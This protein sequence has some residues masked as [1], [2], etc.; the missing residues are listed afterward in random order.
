MLIVVPNKTSDQSP[1]RASNGFSMI[2]VLVSLF[3]LAVGLLGLATLQMTNLK[4][5]HSAQ[6]RTTA[7]VL[8][9]SL[10]DRIRLNKTADYTLAMTADPSGSTLKDNDLESWIDTVETSLPDGDGSVSIAGDIVTVT[11]Q[12][13]DSRGL[14]GDDEQT[15]SVSTQR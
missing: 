9:Y 5:N 1:I 15:F 11:V 14:E 4:N 3:I 10:L 6:Q 13:N 8:A 7:S 2:E 12:W